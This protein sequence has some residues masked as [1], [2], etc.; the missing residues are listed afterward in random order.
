MLAR[1]QVAERLHK[2]L[3]EIDGMTQGEFV[4]WLA[5]FKLKAKADGYN[6]EQN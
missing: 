5:Y 6:Q 3:G 2:T 1:H 4:S